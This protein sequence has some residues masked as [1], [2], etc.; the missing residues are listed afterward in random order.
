M[1]RR[2]ERKKE[3][4]AGSCPG[5]GGSAQGRGGSTEAGE[6]KE[7]GRRRRMEK[8]PRHSFSEGTCRISS[9][10]KPTRI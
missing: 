6:S 1:L 9:R 3:E 8:E 7:E 4:G 5:E 2:R 10:S